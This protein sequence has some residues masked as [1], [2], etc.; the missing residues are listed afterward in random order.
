MLLS[1][2]DGLFYPL[3]LF[4]VYTAIGMSEKSYFSDHPKSK[5]I[6]VILCCKVELPLKSFGSDHFAGPWF[7]GEI[8]RGHIGMLFVHGIYLKQHWI[9]GSLSYYYGLMQVS[10]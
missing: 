3:F 2:T 1:L 8:M 6:S 9:P 7:I 4:G 10:C 5:I